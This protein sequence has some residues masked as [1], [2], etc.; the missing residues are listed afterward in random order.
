ML[1]PV[2]MRSE[3]GAGAGDRLH[4]GSCTWA[5]ELRTRRVTLL[6]A[7]TLRRVLCD[8]CWFLTAQGS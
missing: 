1:A 2:A 5:V 6:L 7:R 8:V 3:M 4:H